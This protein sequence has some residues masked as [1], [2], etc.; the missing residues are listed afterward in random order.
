MSDARPLQQA[1]TGAEAPRNITRQIADNIRDSILNGELKI[2]ERLSTEDDLAER[3]GVSVPTIR[4]A[5]KRLAA[6]HLI[7]SKRGPGGGIFV[8]RP[9]FEQARENM[10]GIMM[11][12]SSLG[13]FSLIDIAEFRHD[14]GLMCVTYA[15]Q[16]RTDDDLAALERELALQEDATI[17]DVD[18]CA[19][20]VRF[21]Q[22]LAQAT[23]NGVYSFFLQ[24]LLEVLIPPANMVVFKFRDRMLICGFHRRIL[25]G[26][27]SRNQRA[28]EE[29]FIELMGYL[30]TKYA[31]AQDWRRT[32][33]AKS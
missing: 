5:L 18:F 22:A 20:D 31:E 26:V 25:L 3:Y 29:A 21:H 15:V 6:Q 10:V 8:N 27:Y 30:R 32:M 16:R 17:S 11:M 19:A 33:D 4:E 13:S 14:M 1:E 24:G 2:D 23:G 7:R 12:L 9:S 28:A